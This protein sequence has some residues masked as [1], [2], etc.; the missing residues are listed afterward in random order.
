MISAMKGAGITQV[1]GLL[2]I[3]SLLLACAPKA[4]I[5][6]IGSAKDISSVC[7][8]RYG[9]IQN[10]LMDKFVESEIVKALR[11]SGV[12]VTTDCTDY[13]LEYHY[14]VTPKQMYVPRIVY[15]PSEAITFLAYRLEEGKAIPEIYTLVPPP[16]TYYYT[17]VETLYVHWINLRLKKEEHLLW[18]GEVSYE[19]YSPDIRASIPVIVKKLIPYLGKDTG[20]M[21]EVELR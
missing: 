17:D 16:T 6:T 21:I 8:K 13:T 18:T 5:S 19:S 12:K 9:K 15:G 14:G 2:V 1:L 10:P 20:K 4:Y 3:F 11:K 7:L